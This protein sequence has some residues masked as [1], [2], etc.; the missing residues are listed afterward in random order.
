VSRRLPSI[1]DQVTQ[2]GYRAFECHDVDVLPYLQNAKGF[3]DLLNDYDVRLVAVYCPEQFVG[4]TFLDGLIVKYYLKEVDR[5]EKFVK[6]A[7]ATGCERVLV[8]GSVGKRSVYRE[9]DYVTMAHTLN[10]MGALCR[11]H[12]LALDYHPHLDTIVETDAQVAK[13]CELTDPE[14]VG[15]TLETGHL[16]VRNVDLP[17][18]V[19]RFADRLRHVHLKDVRD[20]KFVELGTGQVNFVDVIRALNDVGYDGWIVVEEEVN[21][22]EFLWAGETSRTPLESAISSL[23]Y[24]EYLRTYA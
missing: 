24:L 6:F 7:Q 17:A 21:S 14:L 23:K 15:I 20:G 13:V 3:L 10:R 5:L 8:G 1:L 2:S 22:P 12:G 18:F 16:F 19:H 11:D 9:Q 4:K